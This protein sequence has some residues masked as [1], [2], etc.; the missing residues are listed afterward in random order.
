MEAPLRRLT[1]SQ[2]VSLDGDVAGPNGEL[3]WAV[4]DEELHTQFNDLERAIE[5]HLSWSRR[6][7]AC[8]RRTAV[9]DCEPRII[10]VGSGAMIVTYMVS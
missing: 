4:V 8:E 10:Y 7:P 6:P 9:D 5:A 3:D 1:H 2:M